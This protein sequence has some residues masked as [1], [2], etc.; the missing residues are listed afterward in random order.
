[1]ARSQALP[2]L[3]ARVSPL[4]AGLVAPWC[5]TEAA[6]PRRVLSWPLSSPVTFSLP[7]ADD[8]LRDLRGWGGSA[9]DPDH[10][11][12]GRHLSQGKRRA[13]QLSSEPSS[14][15]NRVAL[16]VNDGVGLL[17]QSRQIRGGHSG[18]YPF[19]NPHP[20][21]IPPPPIL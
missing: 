15:Y 14:R 4:V 21:P 20:A 10:L 1:M 8:K 16:C 3:S 6:R 18:I 7:Q 9:F 11:L 17:V 5:H 19:I 13:L 12:T 2:S